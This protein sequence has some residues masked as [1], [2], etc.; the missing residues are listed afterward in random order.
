MAK[1]KFPTYEEALRYVT[2]KDEAIQ[3]FFNQTFDKLQ[4][5]FV[6]ENLPETIPAND[7]EYIL[8][9]TGKAFITEVDGNL[10]AFRCNDGGEVDVYYHPKTVIVTNEALQFNKELEVGKDGVLILNDYLRCG[11]YPLLSKYGVLMADAEISMRTIAILA[12]ITMLISASD[13]KTRAS[14]D[15][16][17]NQIMDGKFGVIAESQFLDGVRMQAPNT[18][19]ATRLTDFVELMQYYRATFHNEIGL[20]QNYNMKRERL[21]SKEIA[22]N[23]DV[24]LPLTDDMLRER[25][26][27]IELLNDMYG[28]KYG[29]EA[30]VDFGSA[31]KREH[32]A[33]EQEIDKADTEISELPIVAG[34]LVPPE[35]TTGGEP[36]DNPADD[37]DGEDDTAADEGVIDVEDFSQLNPE[38]TDE[39]D[40][41]DL[42]TASGDEVEV[43]VSNEEIA[44]EE[45][46]EEDD[47]D[48]RRSSE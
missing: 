28:E 6:Y 21:N 19:S 9:T 27:G 18:N 14:A 29:F 8:Q 17:V 10:W 45:G 1:T 38:D 43:A 4:S 33:L 15:A 26:L 34:E 37:V 48:K 2:D 13:D 12:R 5:M 31:W 16:F 7:L 41:I 46:G 40:S 24:I 20:Q 44:E 30:S 22:A 23:T 11:L 39:E 35:Y 3:S 42:D 32:E 47:E 36:A 25:K